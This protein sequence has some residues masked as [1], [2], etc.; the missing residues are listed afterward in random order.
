MIKNDIDPIL[1]KELYGLYFELFDLK[2]EDVED[3]SS[4]RHR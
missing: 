2:I 4:E 1:K 3:D